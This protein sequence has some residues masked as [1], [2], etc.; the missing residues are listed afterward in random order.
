MAERSDR[1]N[2]ALTST[3]DRGNRQIGVDPLAES[4]VTTVV[5]ARVPNADAELLRHEAERQGLTLSRVARAVI[6]RGLEQT[7]LSDHHHERTA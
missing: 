6:A 1:D 3:D 2:S 7:R 4:T 5:A